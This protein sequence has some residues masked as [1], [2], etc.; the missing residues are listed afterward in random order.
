V[1]DEGG[2]GSWLYLHRNFEKRENI[3]EGYKKKYQLSSCTFVGLFLEG[4]VPIACT[5]L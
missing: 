3:I 4:S 5:H 1:P 2:D